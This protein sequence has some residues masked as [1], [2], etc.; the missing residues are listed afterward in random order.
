MHAKTRPATF[1]KNLHPTHHK[2]PSESSSSEPVEDSLS[3]ASLA[4]A[5]AS[6]AGIEAASDGVEI[7]A[8]FWYARLLTSTNACIFSSALPNSMRIWSAFSLDSLLVN[9][10]K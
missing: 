7:G 8:G 1:Q 9:E 5:T 2:L 3:A 10:Q 6:T 4:A